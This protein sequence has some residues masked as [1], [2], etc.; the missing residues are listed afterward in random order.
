MI[1]ELSIDYRVDLLA[2]PEPS[3]AALGALGLCFLVGRRI[4]RR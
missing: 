2:V 3:A 4:R 1:P